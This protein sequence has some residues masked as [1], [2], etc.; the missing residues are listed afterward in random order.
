MR[1][2]ILSAV[3]GFTSDSADTRAAAIRTVRKYGRFA[4]PLLREANT[5]KS[6]FETIQKLA[7][8]ATQPANTNRSG[9][10]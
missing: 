9:S 8:A 7:E 2:E 1:Q 6:S 5:S 10:E 4:E 3:A